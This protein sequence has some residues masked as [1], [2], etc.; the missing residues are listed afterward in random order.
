MELICSVYLLRS[1][2]PANDVPCRPSRD[3]S[4]VYTV[5]LAILERYIGVAVDAVDDL[6]YLGTEAAAAIDEIVSIRIA[7]VFH[8]LKPYTLKE[9][10]WLVRV[11]LIVFG[12]LLIEDRRM[13]RIDPYR[14]KPGL[15]DAV[16]P[17][18]VYLRCYG[19]SYLSGEVTGR[20]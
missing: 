9:K 17:L 4:L 15:C 6:G 2:L 20:R 1:Y 11:T 19:I 3:V 7:G 8:L 18:F 14:V 16:D 5:S 10:K 13:K 12:K